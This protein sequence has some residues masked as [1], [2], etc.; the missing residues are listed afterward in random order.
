MELSNVEISTNLPTTEAQAPE[1]YSSNDTINHMHKV[2]ETW[3][4]YSKGF[5]FVQADD[6]RV[7]N[8]SYPKSEKMEVA[9]AKKGIVSAFQANFEKELTRMEGDAAGRYLARYK[10]APAGGGGSVVRYSRNVATKD[11]RYMP[12]LD[13]T[14]TSQVRQTKDRRGGDA[15]GQKGTSQFIMNRREEYTFNGRVL[16]EAAGEHAFFF[17]DESPTVWEMDAATSQV[18]AEFE[19][20][21]SARGQFRVKRLKCARRVAKVSSNVKEEE[22]VMDEVFAQFNNT[23]A[24]QE[25]MSRLRRS[26][27]SVSRAIRRLH[28]DR[29][30]HKLGTTLQQLMNLET[31]YG[32]PSGRTSVTAQVI[33]YLKRIFHSKKENDVE[34]RKLLYSLLAPSGDADS[35]KVLLEAF[36]RLH[37]EGEGDEKESLLTYLAFLKDATVETVDKL[38]SMVTDDRD[39]LLLVLGSLAE[40]TSEPVQEEIVTKLQSRLSTIS[41]STDNEG[42]VVLLHSLGNTGSPQAMK[43]LLEYVDDSDLDVQK[44]AISGLRMFTTLQVVQDA[45]TD[46]LKEDASEEIVE[47]IAQTLISGLRDHTQ[48]A[49]AEGDPTHLNLALVRAALKSENANLHNLVFQYLKEVGTEDAD[50]LMSVLMEEAVSDPIYDYDN[51]NSSEVSRRRRDSTSYW[52]SSS[53]VYNI[54]ASYGTRSNDVRRFP[55]YRSY[56]WANKYGA[57]KAY[58]HF[59]AGAFAGYNS[60]CHYKIFGKAIAQGHAFGRTAT[61]AHVEFLRQRTSSTSA[62]Q[63]IYVK[64]FTKVLKS[65]SGTVSLLCYKR[66]YNLYQS[67]RIRI[68]DFSYS[69]FIYVGYLRFSVSVYATLRADLKLCAC[70]RTCTACATVVGRATV[71]PSADASASLAELVRGG[72][73]VSGSITY[74]LE[75][76][77]CAHAYYRRIRAA[78]YSSWP[79]SYVDLYAYYQIRSKFKLWPP[80]KFEWR[81]GD[82]KRWDKLSTRWS[83]GSGSR[84]LLYGS[85]YAS[86][87]V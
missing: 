67:S 86:C 85:G 72:I 4:L 11:I 15:E 1:E 8:V 54:I 53:S 74:Q 80:W 59:G 31:K 41:N 42:K 34:M 70:E 2:Q 78:L 6:G 30:T 69:I 32:P 28:E 46:L 83:I 82:K 36:E 12:G 84:R 50:K 73:T 22:L 65:T 75:P 81:W 26:I 7:V 40:F 47:T 9:N 5:C 35:Q 49:D 76:E 25:R 56:L 77:V 20:R 24:D 37:R 55:T 43:V 68:L 33:T 71:I 3:L 66:T 19:D 17:K 10:Y 87:N 29:S 58:A 63:K 16:E 61:A 38:F 57:S 18:D 79:S 62:Y 13:Q 14:R 21:I 64:V 45:L 52:A 60:N 51:Y 39:P 27:P 48:H 23:E 44:V